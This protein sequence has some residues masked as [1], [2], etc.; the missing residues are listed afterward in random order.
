MTVVLNGDGADELF[1]GYRRYITENIFFKQ[2]IYFLSVF[3][4]I[5]LKPKNKL[6]IY[7]YIY[8]FMHLINKKGIDKYLGLTTD[9]FEDEFSFQNNNELKKISEYLLKC[10]LKC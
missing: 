4:K 3:K 6:S 10:N 5:A 7:N 9:I 8:R 1:G 2:I